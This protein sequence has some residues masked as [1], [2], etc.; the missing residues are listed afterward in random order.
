MVQMKDG[1]EKITMLMKQH[2]KLSQQQRVVQTQHYKTLKHLQEEFTKVY[3][4]YKQ[5]VNMVMGRG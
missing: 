5:E 3:H 1:E 2:H 4:N